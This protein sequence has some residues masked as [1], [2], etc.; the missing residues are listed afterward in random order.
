MM[1]HEH[2]SSNNRR[3]L[4]PRT[5]L[6]PALVAGLLAAPFSSARADEWQQ[7]ISEEGGATTVCKQGLMNGLHC[8]GSYCDDVSIRCA[9]H[10]NL[11]R[12][13][14]WTPFHSEENEALMCPENYF[15]SKLKCQG[16]YCDDVSAQCTEVKSKAFDCRWLED[17]RAVSEEDGGRL[18][19]KTPRTFVRGIQCS[20]KYCDDKKLFVCTVPAATVTRIDPKWA[21]VDTCAGEGCALTRTITVG[22]SKEDRE[23]K[24]EEWSS[25]LTASL[26]AT[27]GGDAAGGSV[28]VGLSATFSESQRRELQKAL[29]TSTTMATEASCGE[30]GKGETKAVYQYQYEVFESCVGDG[31]CSPAVI[32]GTSTVCV[33]DP[34]NGAANFSPRCSPGCCKNGLCTECHTEGICAGEPAG[35]VTAQLA[36]KTDDEADVDESSE[37]AASPADAEA[38]GGCGCRAN[39]RD[40]SSAP[41]WLGM[42]LLG[43]F[44]W[45][46]RRR[47]P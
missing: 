19:T 14:N 46:R 13:T 8:K 9:S 39:A 30:Q 24:G 47:H 44:G 29:T 38:S 43:L 26:E 28:T 16:S 2:S 36:A 21:L 20:G 22:I 40:G 27:A 31:T 7:H 3:T 5:L 6:L 41:G 10:P 37:A 23:T 42:G 12:T 45:S 33:I 18:A 32:G 15:I 4:L 1:S 11:G 35:E 34:P 17:G 25:S